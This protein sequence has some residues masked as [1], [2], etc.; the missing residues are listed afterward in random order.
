MSSQNSWNREV[1]Q[2][3]NF[4]YSTVKR[5]ADELTCAGI[6]ID[7]D[8]ARM[9]DAHKGTGGV[10]AHGVLPAV[11]LPFSALINI[12]REGEREKQRRG[13]NK[14]KWDVGCSLRILSIEN[15]TNEITGQIKNK[16]LC[17]MLKADGLLIT[18][19][20]GVVYYYYLSLEHNHMFF[21]DTCWKKSIVFFLGFS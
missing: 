9:A 19:I 15:T 11:V 5:P 16:Q 2:N 4:V 6:V 7:P 20:W 3:Q 14:A 12:W 10:N 17:P 8:V 18:I 13:E 1:E 21:L